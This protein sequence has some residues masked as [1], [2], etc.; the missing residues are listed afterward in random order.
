[1]A[2]PYTVLVKPICIGNQVVETVKTYKL[3]RVT[4]KEG[5]KCNLHVDR[6]EWRGGG[7]CLQ[8]NLWYSPPASMTSRL[9]SVTFKMASK[10]LIEESDKNFDFIYCH[11]KLDLSTFWNEMS[12]GVMNFKDS[13]LSSSK[14]YGQLYRPVM[15]LR[16]STQLD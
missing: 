1:M 5:L 15:L 8:G 2:N 10:V 11:R 13:F 7:R 16:A 9:A 12:S 6:G 14:F 4:I 3:L